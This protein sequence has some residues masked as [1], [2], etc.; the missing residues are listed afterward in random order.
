MS[1]TT[2]PHCGSPLR[3]I[4]AR[5]KTR[6]MVVGH[7]ECHCPESVAQRA[8]ERAREASEEKRGNEIRLLEALRLSG[9]PERF[10]KAEHP[11]AESIDPKKNAYIFG[12][13]GSGKTHLACAVLRREGGG[14]FASAAGLIQELR[15]HQSREYDA[16]KSARLLVLDDLGKQSSSD[17][18][19]E[20][21]FSLIDYRYSNLLP[22]IVTSNYKPS[23]LAQR[24]GEMGQAVVSRLTQDGQVVE[25]DGQD[26]RRGCTR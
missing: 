26:R 4:V 15:E 23:A 16:C 10:V 2:C 24:L 14:R 18:A 21:I 6:E 17:Y 20:Q 7:Y 11:Q 5:F 1:V 25:L 12:G 13:V 19:S 3:P 8:L 9:V 22:T